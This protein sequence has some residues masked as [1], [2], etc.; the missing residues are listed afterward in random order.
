MFDSWQYGENTIASFAE[1]HS[2]SG[3]ASWV[4]TGFV[5]IL[6]GK[7]IIALL[8]DISAWILW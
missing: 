5:L 2:S 6:F 1:K 8:F 7:K 3:H 4:T